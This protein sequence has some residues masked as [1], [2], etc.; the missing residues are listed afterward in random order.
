[1]SLQVHQQ[2]QDTLDYLYAQLPIFSKYGKGA[3]KVGLD[4]IKL[5]C[6]ALGNPQSKLKR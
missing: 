2:Y 6:E 5:L 1:V 3:I 4:N